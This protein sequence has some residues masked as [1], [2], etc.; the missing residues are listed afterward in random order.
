MRPRSNEIGVGRVEH[1]AAGRG[2]RDNRL[3]LRVAD[4]LQQKLGVAD[5]KGIVLDQYVLKMDR[6]SAALV[7]YLG[8]KALNVGDRERKFLASGVCPFPGAVIKS[9]IDRS[10]FRL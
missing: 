8:A 10:I 6:T 7:F 1:G 9:G 4:F 5:P 2:I 3:D